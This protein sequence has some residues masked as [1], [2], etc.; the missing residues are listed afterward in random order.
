MWQDFLVT[1]TRWPAV[2]EKC[3]F[4]AEVRSSRGISEWERNLRCACAFERVSYAFRGS[5]RRSSPFC[6]A[7]FDGVLLGTKY[8]NRWPISEYDI[9]LHKGN[10]L[11]STGLQ[12][13]LGSF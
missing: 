4:D 9:W 13:C 8:R 5:L 6:L 2:R 3:H 11:V 7:G 12:P 1:M 10:I